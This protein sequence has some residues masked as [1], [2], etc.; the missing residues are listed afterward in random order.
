[1]KLGINL[2][3]VTLLFASVARAQEAR[4]TIL[5]RVT[6]PTGAIVGT[7]EVKATNVST[8]V[9]VSAKTNESGIY[10]IPYLVAGFYNIVAE[11]TGFKK[12]LR[13]NVQV[14]VGDRVEVDIQLAIGDIAEQVEVK[15]DTPLLS[16]ADATLGQVVDERRVLELPLFSGNAMEFELM[17]PGAVNTT[18]MR[19]RKAPFNNAPSQFST[20]G[21]GTYNNEFTID[22]V[23]NTFSDSTQVR[24]A[25]SPPQAAIGE[26]KV[27]TSTFDAAVGHT[28]GSL[29]N[30]STKG[31][32]NDI[33]GSAWWWI[34]NKMFDT[35]T[36]FQNRSGQKLPQYTDNRYGLSGGG[37]VVIP[38]IYN[39]RN[40]TFWQMTWEVN[41]F[42]DPAVG[43]V[44]STVPRAAWKTG[45][46][47]DLLKLGTAYQVYDPGTIQAAPNG[48]FSRQ[49]FAGNIIPASRLDPI[50]KNI[51]NL[52]PL[53]NQAGTSDGRNNYFVS[54]RT[55]ENYWTTIGRVDHN[56][57]QK[58]RSFL[59]FH[60]DYWLEDKNH[61]FLY[62]PAAKN[63]NG[64]Y[65]NRIN[66]G[67]AFD[68]VHEF[69]PSLVLQV[70]YGVAAQE[71]PERRVNA[72]YDLT[73]LGFSSAFAAL[74][75]K[76]K[77]AI[78]NISI[79]SLSALSGSES[80]D[81]TATSLSHTVTGNFILTR[82]N[83]ILHFGPD[84]RVYRVFS[85]RHSG[86]DAPILSFSALW[87]TGP[88][89]NS[90]A[91][92]VGG[93]LVSA[94]LGIPNGNA[95]R[96]GSFAQQDIY[97]GLYIQDDWKLTRKLTVN[98]GLRTE[99][100]SALT[101]RF[102]RSVTTFLAG[103]PSP[104][105]AQAI[106]NYAK[107][108]IPEVPVSSFKV[109]GGLAFASDSAR[110][111]WNANG[112]MWMPRVGLAYQIDPKTVVR[113][114][115]GIFY[116]SI[117]AFNSTSNLAGFSQSTPI[118]PSPDNGLTF[119]VKMSNPLP[120]GILAPLGAAGGL[121]TNLG[122]S[123]SYFANDRKPSY[124][125][126]WSI[127]LQ[128]QL[129]GN[130]MVEA[131]YVGNRATHLPVSRNINYIPAQ[132]LSRAPIRDTA[133][134][135]YLGQQFP[136]PFYGLNPQYTST[137]ISRSGL[138]LPYPQ[139]GNITYLDPAGY[140]WY[141]ALQSQ[142]EKRFSKGFTLQMAYTWS[143]AM[144]AT[145]FLNAQD[146][147]PYRSLSSIDR[148]HRITGSGIWELP[149]GHGRK[150]GAHMNPVLNFIA[151]GWQLS[152][153]FQRQSGQPIDWGQMII[154]G[155]STKLALPSDQRN[156]DH[157]F[158][159]SIFDRASGDQL[160]SNIRTFPLRFSNVRFDSQRR[161]DLSA[162]K[163]FPISERF[164]LRFR[165]DTFNALN[166]PVL[167]GPNTTAT[168]SAFG[169]STDQ[170]PPR[171]FQFS[172]NLQF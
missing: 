42:G 34:R 47:S 170:E 26:F 44:T 125:Q 110:N 80:G 126:R 3:I 150:W 111:L 53:P 167:R 101:E 62:D 11:N 72:P 138:L 9:A 55:V 68:H 78:P 58:D 48:R 51:L 165:G 98:L 134:I 6:D 60:R 157:W 8:G 114:G 169:T 77:T 160:A 102:N 152:G 136:N 84:F 96:S 137:T 87:G 95:T 119:P 143:R 92:T 118:T 67:I 149:F 148:A 83:H 146:P 168:S 28:Q 94:L 100:D 147:L 56:W 23:P 45:D 145:S 18:D 103:Q 158:N 29:V 27:Q 109:N 15:A 120:N 82:G 132:Y 153:A 43:A 155:D 12:F 107:S 166:T 65:L 52:Y 122:Q 71:F 76:D 69:S 50:G 113:S 130:F 93:E 97:T 35:P 127:G 16:T 139:F 99:Y 151:G 115:Y 59:R 24:V 31:G 63:V 40:K 91:P 144:E 54:G 74:F 4:G 117:G 81:G 41:D 89:D 5:G 1:M 154:T 163:I 105:A 88:L 116:G 162:N 124:A 159:T 36:I 25:F 33:H 104:I 75:P 129:P 142:A 121:S 2:L 70:R 85:D 39:G 90:P 161:L 20:D 123:I 79:G 156:T 46:L 128:R 30:I 131:S 106:A 32:G 172:L 164:K 108:P 73:S 37:P 140:S 57:S 135:N 7:A 17:A 112:M 19:L 49:P 61:N 66:R 86:D 14:R 22:G 38:K 10:S 141:H 133:T 64:I 13:E 171:S 21:G